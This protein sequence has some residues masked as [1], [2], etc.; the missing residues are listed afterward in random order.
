MPIARH[1]E[2]PRCPFANRPTCEGVG[3]DHLAPSL[4][5][6]FPGCCGEWM[7]GHREILSLDVEPLDVKSLDLEVPMAQQ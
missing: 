2:G 3:F 4:G 1:R 5:F 7:A 6:D